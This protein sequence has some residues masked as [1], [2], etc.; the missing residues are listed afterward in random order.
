MTRSALLL[1]ASALALNL[2]ACNSAEIGNEQET[3]VEAKGLGIVPAS[4]DKTV[5][6]GDDFFSFANGT[7]VKNTPIPP[8][9]SNIGG[10]TIADMER[11]KNTK[12]MLA[13]ILKANPSADS[14]EGRIANYYRAYLDT[15]AIDRAGM[16]PAQADIQAIARI[17]DRKQL[18]AAI[19]SSLRADTDPLNATNFHTGNLFGVFVTQGLNTPGET[20]PYLMQG[21]IG[22]PEREYYLS[23]DSDMAGI[24]DKYKS[25][26]ATVLQAAGIADAQGAADRVLA[27]ETKIA[28]AHVTREESED[29]AKGATVWTR[30]ELERNAPGIDWG[31]LLGAAQ[32][33]NA[34]KFDAYHAGAIPKLAALVGSEPLRSWKEWMAFHLLNDNASVLPKPIRDASFAFNGTTLSGTPQQRPR[35]D[36]ALNA[37]SNAL[38]DAVG[39]AYVDRYFPAAAKADVSRMA[40]NIKAAFVR[41]VEAIDWMAPSTKDEALKKARGIIVG[42]G[43]PDAWRSYSSVTIDPTTPYANQK[44]ARLAEYRHQ[45]AKIGKPM[46][47]NEWWMPPQ[48]VNAVNIPVA[49]TLN[50]PAAILQPPFYDA[51]AD[52]AANYGAIGAVIGHEISHSFDNNGALFDASGRLRNWWT[53]ADFQRFQAAGT[54]LAAQ[55]DAYEALPGLRVNGKLTLG[56]N[57][58]DVAGLGAAYDAYRASLGGKEAPVI[59]GFTGD[60]RFFIAYGQ[61]W[62]SKLREETMRQRVLTN[63]HAPGQ[64]RALTVRN[65]APWYAAFGVQPGQR[66]FLKPEE[67]VKVW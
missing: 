12:A 29:F 38:Q 22:L 5:K 46:D 50:F 36:Q 21:G 16:A 19:G 41:R 20:L 31:A 15:A 3:A 55:Y 39:K 45:I 17:A 56:E 63:G 60:Q 11:E 47:R 27:L 4:M 40:D 26:I 7:W 61:A 1:A 14:D 62:A 54:A 25:Y 2:S 43:Y 44:A 23:S 8:D 66:L 48:L 58:A 10:F 35:E 13:E 52:P 24:R 65:L 42:V 34:P 9:Q 64:F 53:P 49:N 18:S 28:Q 51:K 30:A 37:T 57:I 6:P 32:L 67:R 59:D 33:G